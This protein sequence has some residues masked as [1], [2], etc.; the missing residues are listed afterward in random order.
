MSLPVPLIFAA[1]L[2]LLLLGAE[3]LVRGASRL[4]AAMNV[5]PLVIGLTVVAFG[6]SSPELA[7][8]LVSARLGS[9]DLA[10]GNVVGSN[11]F[12]ILVILGLAALVS[13]LEVQLKIV[14]F[15]VPI[16][17]GVG[18][19]VPLIAAN[20]TIGRAE[21]A[22]LILL[23]FL[24]LAFLA[25]EARR[26][27]VATAG[28]D[29][30]DRTGLA[31]AAASVL[32]G[33][34]MLTLGASWLVGAA[35]SLARALGV[36]EL[37]IGLTLVAGGTSLPELATSVVAALRGQRDLAVGNVIGSN[38]FNVLGVLGLTGLLS[39]GGVAVS[40]SARS[41]DLPILVAASLACLPVFATGLRIDRWEGALFLA[42]YLGYLG[43][44]L[45]NS[46]ATH[47]AAPWWLIAALLGGVALRAMTSLRSGRRP[48]GRS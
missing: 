36:S 21:A 40:A 1:G 35:T 34:A 38:I 2:A 37:I 20:G 11:T 33:L 46:R 44:L 41:F 3:L 24:Y 12:N 28:R 17:I 43:T 5:S 22:T 25:L 30:P 26:E 16:M 18:F 6:T 47:V 31:L 39:R 45:H 23:L 10:L 48:A 29:E 27:G 7:A 9:T 14:R 19:L 4:A 13:P 15:D 8:S 32:A 42:T